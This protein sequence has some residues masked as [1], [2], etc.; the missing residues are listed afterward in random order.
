MTSAQLG[1]IGVVLQLK[2]ELSAPLASIRANLKT[3]DRDAQAASAAVSTGMTGMVSS[4][5]SLAGVMGVA[6]SVGAMK[7]WI[8]STLTAAGRIQDLSSRLNV[9]TKA[10]QQWAFAASQSG[11]TI[12]DVAASV[13]FMNRT[14]AGDSAEA[15]Q[16]VG[17]EFNQIRQL[18]PEEA[19]NAIVTALGNMEDPMARTRAQYALLGRGSADLSA[20]IAEG[21]K[22]VADG[23]SYMEQETI[24]RLDAA[25]DAWDKLTRDVTIKSGELIAGLAKEFSKPNPIDKWFTAVNTQFKSFG[26][27]VDQAIADWNRLVGKTGGAPTAPAPPSIVNPPLVLPVLSPEAQRSLE[28]ALDKQREALD[29]QREALDA[30]AKAAEAEARALRLL[31]NQISGLTGIEEAQ[32]LARAVAFNATRGFLTMEDA[33][34]KKVNETLYEGIQAS[35][36]L[37]RTAS[38]SMLRAY[39][40]T[41]DFKDILDDIPPLIQGIDFTKVGQS[42]TPM[43]NALGEINQLLGPMALR[44]DQIVGG[45]GLGKYILPKDLPLPDASKFFTNTQLLVKEAKEAAK[46]VGLLFVND[47]ST[48]L[49]DNIRLGDWSQVENQLSSALSGTLSAG[50]AAAINLFAPGLGTALQPLFQALSEKLMGA[51]GLGTKGR[52]LV[53]EFAGTV[54]G[55]DALRAQLATLGPEGEKLW[56]ALTQGVGRNNPKQAQDAIDA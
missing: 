21:F 26:L 55:F 47:L 31:A 27:N 7:S 13:S 38:A 48:S 2:D 37:G 50:V 32:R 8:D 51:L 10:V 36:R 42:V 23:A 40:A 28:D 39:K 15:L 33:E 34:R 12:D 44:M 1:A 4:L 41:Y 43:R 6:F 3:F 25:G 5:K 17:L 14:L 22:N 19:F 24:D 35:E 53:K 54:G 56:I 45:E 49:A 30:A 11:G 9:S 52:D 29:K 46:Q 16:K 18:K 20:A